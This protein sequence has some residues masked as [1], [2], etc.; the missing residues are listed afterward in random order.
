[1]D[2]AGHLQEGPERD[3]PVGVVAHAGR[4]VLPDRFVDIEV[5]EGLRPRHEHRNLALGVAPVVARDILN[6][7][8]DPPH[9]SQAAETVDPHALEAA[10]MG[11]VDGFLERTG[12]EA[13]VL[14]SDSLELGIG[15]VGAT[16]LFGRCRRGGGL[17]IRCGDRL[18]D[19]HTESEYAGDRDHA[20]TPG[21]VHESSPPGPRQRRR[22]DRR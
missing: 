8:V 5:A 14:R 22:T 7:L 11:E 1:M 13:D 15:R 16:G 19:P 3:A 21:T 4:Q 20:S 10:D 6:R 18:R 9:G 12:V 2:P 17:A